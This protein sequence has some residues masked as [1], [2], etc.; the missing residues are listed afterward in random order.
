MSAINVTDLTYRYPD[1]YENVFDNLTLTLDTDWK[2]ALTG[3]NGRGKT[4]FLR[5]LCGKL[6]CR[7]GTIRCP[8]PL[9]YFPF[10]AAEEFDA[11]S[12]LYAARPAM[13]LWK[14]KR[15]MRGLGLAEE[16]LERPYRTLSGGERTKLQ[17]AA[18]FSEESAYLLI[19][20]PTNH[21]DRAGREKLAA[22]LKGKL[23]F[24]LVSHDRAFLDACCDH[25][26]VFGAEGYTLRR[27]SFSDWWKDKTA[28]DKAESEQNE[29]LKKQIAAMQKS[30]ERMS[31]WA[32]KV[33]A[34]K[35]K[36]HKVAGL[37]PEK[38]HV[39]RMAAK[40]AK[41]A[42]SVE[43]RQEK[44]I[45][46]KSALLKDAEF[47][48]N[49]KLSPLP[50][51]AQELCSLT[52]VSAGYG[53]KDA[54][55]DKTLTIGRGERIA[56][57]GAN[58]C[59]KS[60]LL[61]L[62]AG[63]IEPREG[64]VRVPGDLTVSYLPQ[65]VFAI[66]GSAAEYA[67]AGGAP[68]ALVMAILNKLNFRSSLFEKDISAYSEGQKKKMALAVSLATPAHLYIWDEPLNYIDLVSRIQLEELILQFC[69]TLLFVEHDAEFC[70]KI[71]TK[72]MFL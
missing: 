58:G 67:A 33:E 63:R 44:A 43:R 23:G 12:A 53:G 20:E 36:K 35:N 4:T 29:R 17:L 10:A 49:L 66:S 57:A 28:A 25:I 30:A 61:K 37:P 70:R 46:E 54:I 38:G 69:P 31:G 27:G 26:L 32:D 71:A 1:S 14:L 41:R 62:L 18:L 9:E 22:Y 64:I 11:L 15:E 60:T 50:F 48:G 34:S 47:Y 56:V 3:R 59:G 39:G 19:D 5:L 2:L 7:Q 65:D 13:E 16:V 72:T 21:L 45:E 6:E 55:S 24:I 8:V 51:R 52:H 42:K 40:M 68:P